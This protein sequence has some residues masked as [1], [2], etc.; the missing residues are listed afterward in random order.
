MTA[1]RRNRN[2]LLSDEVVDFYF[3][4]QGALY[5]WIFQSFPHGHS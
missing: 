5:G 1:T 4:E 2:E 3:E